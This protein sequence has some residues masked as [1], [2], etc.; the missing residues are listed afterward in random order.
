[1]SYFPE[2]STNQDGG[3]HDAGHGM[4]YTPRYADEARTIFDGITF[5]HPCV[6]DRHPDFEKWSNGRTGVSSEPNSGWTHTNTDT[7]ERLTI[8]PSIQCVNCGFHGF[9]TEGKWQPV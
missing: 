5:W 8:T 9:L 4:R 1:M 7:P 2:G 6:Q 3:K